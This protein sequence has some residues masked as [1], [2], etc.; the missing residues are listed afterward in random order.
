MCQDHRGLFVNI[1][2]G[3][4]RG[5]SAQGSLSLSSSNPTMSPESSPSATHTTTNELSKLNKRDLIERFVALQNDHAERGKK[6]G[7]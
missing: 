7:T 6:Y 1:H 5:R 2:F 3:T 4:F